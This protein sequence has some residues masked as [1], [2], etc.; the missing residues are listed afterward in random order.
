MNA[1]KPVAKRSQLSQT[2]ILTCRVGDQWIGFRVQQ[3][4]EVVTQQKR[5]VMPLSPNAVVGLI[6]L[7]GKVITEL[8]VRTVVGLPK[9]D[10]DAS[11][12][13]AIVETSTN[14]DFG[15]I[16]DDVGEVTELDSNEFEPTPHS[17]DTVWRQVSDGVLKQKDRVLVVVNVDRFIALTVPNATKTEDDNV[18][19]H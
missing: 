9:R 14:E 1:L 3:V 6:N 13:M 5:T 4:R 8:D 15:L 18:T 11:F 10:E 12:H 17:L 2:E 19:I 16:V 7:R